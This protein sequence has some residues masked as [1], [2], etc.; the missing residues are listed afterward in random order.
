[1]QDV[2]GIHQ[3][4]SR[5]GSHAVPKDHLGRD[6]AVQFYFAESQRSELLLFKF[7]GQP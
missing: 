7:A 3:L 6:G 5:R 4:H 1:M 2:P